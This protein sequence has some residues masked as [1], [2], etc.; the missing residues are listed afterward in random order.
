MAK[1]TDLYGPVKTLLEAAGYKVKAEVNG[2]DVVAF[3]DD[4]TT[5]IVEL[6]LVFSL[7][8]VLQGINRQS[9]TD[10][11]YLAVLAPDTSTKRKN[12]R[13]RERGYLK[14]CRQL[15]LGLMLVNPNKENELSAKILLDPAPYSPR[16]NKRRQTRLINEFTTRKGDPNTGGINRT[17]IITAYRQDALRCAVA[18]SEQ[19]K[20]K[21]AEVKAKTGVHKTG[22]IL[23]KNYYN[24]FER[25]E[26][27]IYCLTSKGKESLKLYAKVLPTLSDKKDI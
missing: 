19:E 18:L 14:L 15:G 8:L 13:S 26:R 10:D 17:K 1:E 20:M 16:K 25:T 12:W 27:G 6:K 2:C 7:D 24:W 9:L 11:V 4:G 22:S 21:V 3:K 23:Q 5:V